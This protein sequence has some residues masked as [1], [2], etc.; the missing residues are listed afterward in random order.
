VKPVVEAK[1]EKLVVEAKPQAVNITSIVERIKASET[2]PPTV[3]PTV[4]ITSI[5][6]KIKE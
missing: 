3:K 5:V 6:E 1:P 2:A 4:N